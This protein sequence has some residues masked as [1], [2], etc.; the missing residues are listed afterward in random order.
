MTRKMLPAGR[1]V[2]VCPHAGQTRPHSPSL[3]HPAAACRN[4]RLRVCSQQDLPEPAQLIADSSSFPQPLAP[5][6]EYVAGQYAHVL[7]YR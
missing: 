2:A 5:P 6:M 3:R 4:V 7:E 1:G